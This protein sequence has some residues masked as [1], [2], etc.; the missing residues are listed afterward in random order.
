MA[1]LKEE[2]EEELNLCKQENIKITSDIENNNRIIR[3]L[4]RNISLITT[5]SGSVLGEI[6]DVDKQK[7]NLKAKIEDNEEIVRAQKQEQERVQAEGA[8]LTDER[9]KFLSSVT[10]DKIAFSGIEKDIEL[11]R[12][13]IEMLEGE[14]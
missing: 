14:K 7:D 13:K 10:D 12:E 1:Q 2:L 11:C 3:E 4:E 5:E 6:E 9:E 8:A